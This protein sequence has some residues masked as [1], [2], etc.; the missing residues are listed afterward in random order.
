M[1]AAIAIQKSNGFTRRSRRNSARSIIPKTTASMM[2]APRT[3]LGSSEK[4][5]ASRVSVPRTIPP[6]AS[7]ATGFGVAW[8][9]ALLQS[10]EKQTG[11][12]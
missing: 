8:G 3:A 2:I 7:D 10:L 5:G 12:A 11:S 4:R 1:T 9:Y 6:V